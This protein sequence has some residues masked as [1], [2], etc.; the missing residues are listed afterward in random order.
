MT[1]WEDLQSWCDDLSAWITEL[2]EEGE[3]EKAFP[4]GQFPLVASR[5]P[6]DLQCDKNVLAY[7]TVWMC[8]KKGTPAPPAIHARMLLSDSFERPWQELYSKLVT[9]LE[10][11]QDYQD[12]DIFSLAG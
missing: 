8:C 12:I 7:L 4:K 2:G 9:R 10:A 11:K 6:A 1:T 5:D 3:L